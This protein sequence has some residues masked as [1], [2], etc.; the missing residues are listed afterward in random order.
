MKKKFIWLAAIAITSIVM[1]GMFL[2]LPAYTNADSATTVSL[3]D[4]IKTYQQA[5]TGPLN[6]ATSEVKDPEIAQ[7]SQEL[8]QSYELE[9]VGAGDA[10]KTEL[11]D[12]VPDLAKIQKSALNTTLKEAGKQLKDKELSEFYSRFISNCGVN[13]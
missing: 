3:A 2:A 5:L 1:M 13:K 4:F 9:K 10:N 12:L 7:F 6:K 11:S 8:V